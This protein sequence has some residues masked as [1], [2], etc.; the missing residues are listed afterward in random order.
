MAKK[1]IALLIFIVILFLGIV[2]FFCSRTYKDPGSESGNIVDEVE[3]KPLYVWQTISPDVA[4][5]RTISWMG[6]I[7]DTGTLELSYAE[8]GVVTYEAMAVPFDEDTAVYT[9][10]LRSLDPDTEYSYRVSS[11]AGYSDWYKFSTVDE[12]KQTCSALI[13]GDSQSS[14]YS[15]WSGTANA[16]YERNPNIDFFINMG[17]LVDN[18]S[19]LS[20]WRA[21]LAGIAKFSSSIPVAPVMGNHETYGLD[22]K[23]TTPQSF[24][25]LFGVPENSS[26]GIQKHAYSFDYGPVHFVVLDTQFEEEQVALP[27]LLKEQAEWLDKDLAMS[28][29]PWKIILMHRQPWKIPPDGSLNDIGKAFLPIISKHNVDVVFSAH[30]HSYSRTDPL[31]F[32]GG[33]AVYISTGRSGDQVWAKSPQ[34]NDDEKF[35]NP[36]DEPMYLKMDA[37]THKLTVTAY[38]QDGSIIDEWQTQK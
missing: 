29:L 28:D 25:T 34:K 24:Q 17:D 14:D 33:S 35:F 38:K 19:D 10:K 11:G 27:N 12:E 16:A 6:K 20:Q 36:L 30:I 26:Y 23:P 8:H 9:V 4:H 3:G 31:S 15:V 13:F 32:G 1:F 21:W 37:D 2:Y 22:W 18:G 7:N 5:G